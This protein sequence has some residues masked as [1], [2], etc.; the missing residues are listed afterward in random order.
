MEVKQKLGERPLYQPISGPFHVDYAPDEHTVL[1]ENPPRFTWMAAQQED[2]NAYLLQVSGSPS[3]QE[4]ETMTFAQLPY[5]FF[6]PDRVFEPGDY[7]WRYALL[8]DYSVQQ[9]S[10]AEADASQGK[11]QELSAW[12][13]VRRFTV[14]T[15]LPETPLPSRAERYD[16]TDTSHPGC[17]SERVG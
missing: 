17:G 8:V 4:E 14:P 9:G 1:A 7:Y 15:E 11:P 6:T 13:E 12:S 3:F 2:E 16:S 5:N 10:E